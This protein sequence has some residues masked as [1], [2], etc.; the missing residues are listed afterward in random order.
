M[1]LCH[2]FTKGLQT[3][4]LWPKARVW[5]E[6]V[7]LQLWMGRVAGSVVP[8]GQPGGSNVGAVGL[9]DADVLPQVLRVVCQQEPLEGAAVEGPRGNQAEKAG[10]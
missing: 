2:G 4:L 7:L 10:L 6:A 3:A 5:F 1:V 9:S 8:A